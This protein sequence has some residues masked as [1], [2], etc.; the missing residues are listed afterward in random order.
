MSMHHKQSLLYY[1][2]LDFDAVN[3]HEAVAEDFASDSGMPS[4]YQDFMKG[5]WFLDR[6]DFP[7]RCPL[8]FNAWR[9][10]VRL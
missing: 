3:G 10:T 7:V 2:L 8:Q 5:L 9:L 6:E 1:I 4:T